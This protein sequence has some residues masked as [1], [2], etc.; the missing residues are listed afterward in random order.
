[1]FKRT[2]AAAPT[3]P[4]PGEIEVRYYAWP[5][6]SVH[7]TVEGGE[8]PLQLGATFTCRVTA[9]TRLVQER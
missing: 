7:V 8:I 2:E 6:D 3:V 5:V 1:M 4:M 9:V